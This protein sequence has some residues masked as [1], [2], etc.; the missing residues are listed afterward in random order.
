MF[1]IENN[2]FKGDDFKIFMEKIEESKTLKKLSIKWNKLKD[3]INEE[4]EEY[5]KTNPLPKL[6][7]ALM[8]YLTKCKTLEELEIRIEHANNR[9]LR[10]NWSFIDIYHPMS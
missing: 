3:P 9:I 2:S 10:Y 7:E 8:N 1:T 4:L 5:K 6:E